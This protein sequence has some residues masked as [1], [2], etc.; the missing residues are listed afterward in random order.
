M[1]K[2]VLWQ[3]GAIITMALLFASCKKDVPCHCDEGPATMR[4]YATGLNNPRGLKFGPDGYLYVAEGGTGGSHSTV[5][6][7]EQVP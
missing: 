4:V 7:C 3:L 6:Q 5:V 1:K 2:N